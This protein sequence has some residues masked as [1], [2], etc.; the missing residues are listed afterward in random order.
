[1]NKIEAIKSALGIQENLPS[2]DEIIIDYSKS[3]KQLQEK[4]ARGEGYNIGTEDEPVMANAGFIEIWGEII[5]SLQ[6]DG[7]QAL[8]LLTGQRNTYA[9]RLVQ[10]RKGSVVPGP[11]LH[12]GSA[13]LPSQYLETM[14]YYDKQVKAI[15]KN[16]GYKY[17]KISVDGAPVQ[18]ILNRSAVWAMRSAAITTGAGLGYAVASQFVPAEQ[19]IKFSPYA[20][21]FTAILLTPAIVEAR[22]FW[23]KA[24]IF[25]AKDNNLNVSNAN[26]RRS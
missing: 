12:G 23:R 11:Q 19:I 21:G 2:I 9:M 13:Q 7:K 26:P 14:N 16:F 1:M 25:A 10:L 4:L 22:R 3:L 18:D 5:D 15:A 6:T 17:P 24:N 8:T 20:I